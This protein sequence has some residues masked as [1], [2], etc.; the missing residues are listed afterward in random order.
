MLAAGYPI[1]ITEPYGFDNALDPDGSKHANG[2]TW[3][4]SNNTGYLWRGW[5]DWAVRPS[6]LSLPPRPGP[7]ALRLDGGYQ[8][9]RRALAIAALPYLQR[10]ARNTKVGQRAGNVCGRQT[11]LLVSPLLSQSERTKLPRLLAVEGGFLQTMLCT[12]KEL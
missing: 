5:N 11:H 6:A 3:A 12:I 4:A 7:P 9:A 8:L 10:R 1:L 2:Y